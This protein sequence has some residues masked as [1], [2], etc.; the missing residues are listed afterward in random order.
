M[1]PSNEAP[2]CRIY[3]RMPLRVQSA[4]IQSRVL[5]F[6]SKLE[7]TK[8][9]TRSTHKRSRSFVLVCIHCTNS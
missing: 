9:D 3:Q 1:I 2:V 7:R 6:T 4:T 5:A 8:V